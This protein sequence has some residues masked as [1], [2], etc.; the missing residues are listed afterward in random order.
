V[1]VEALTDPE[2]PP[3]PPHIEAEQAKN[4][5]KALLGGDPAARDIIRQS[6]KGKAQELFGR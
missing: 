2:V 3:L 6:V 4:L 5:A 1:V